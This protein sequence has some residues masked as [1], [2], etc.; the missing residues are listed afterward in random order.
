M[1]PKLPL[2]LITLALCALLSGCQGF[3]SG[4]RDYYTKPG[5]TRNYQPTTRENHYDETG[6]YTGYSER[7]GTRQNHYDANGRWVGYS[8]QKGGGK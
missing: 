2:I 5:G 7:R 3:V 8:E 4:V 6:R 1:K